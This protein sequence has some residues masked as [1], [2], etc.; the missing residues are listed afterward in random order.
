MTKRCIEN[1]LR[2]RNIGLNGARCILYDKLC[3]DDCRQ[4][5]NNVALTGKATQRRFIRDAF[6]G[7][8]KERV[9]CK[10]FNI[11]DASGREIVEYG[12]AQALA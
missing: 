4:M 7:K 2:T 11:R 5:E 8:P 6:H 12:H 1:I 3:A 9:A 10:V